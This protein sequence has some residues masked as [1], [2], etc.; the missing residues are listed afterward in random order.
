M[1]PWTWRE[2]SKMN[3]PSPS[4]QKKVQRTARALG[5]LGLVHAYGHC[6]LRLD[7]NSFLVSAS[8]P[9]GLI[10]EESGIV[11]KINEE[12]PEN[13]LGE[14]RVHQAIYR[15]R[16]DVGGI[17]RIMSPN[18]MTLSTQNIVP[19]ARHG[20]GAYFH[21]GPVF[22]EDP[23]LLR[24]N[25]RAVEL[26][27]CLGDQN[28]IVMR[29]NGAV[30][31]SENIETALMLSFFLEDS[32]RIEMDVLQSGFDTEKGFLTGEEIT[33]RQ[34]WSGGVVSRFWMWATHEGAN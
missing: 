31:A 30:I 20:I 22:W 26:A 17:C 9:L 15:L 19:K 27:E 6:S 29:G 32:A 34:I 13:V 7:N 12:L 25:K 4:D 24:D 21:P 5:R 14:V 33:D 23:R 11:V 1:S 3:Q 28:A 16:A 8:K 10:N 2:R 18:I